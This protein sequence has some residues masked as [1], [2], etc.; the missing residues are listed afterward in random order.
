MPE[1]QVAH[2]NALWLAELA[3]APVTRVESAEPRAA[4]HRF[5]SRL[6]GD[7]I[8]A[9]RAVGKHHLL[10][11]AS[12]RVLHSHLRMS[13]SWRRFAP[14]R[15]PPRRGLWL[16]LHTDCGVAA[17]YRCPQVRLLEAHEPLPA[18]IAALGPDLLAEST[19]PVAATLDA[20]RGVDQD[21]PIGEVVLDQRVLAGIGNAY[22]AEALFVLGINPWRPVAE[23]DGTDRAELGAALAGMLADGVR[24]GGRIVT[25]R[26]PGARAGRWV[27]RR[28]GRPC[29]RCATPVRSRPMGDDG[30]IVYWCPTCQPEG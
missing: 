27:H 22:R 29:R 28:S 2:H 10:E 1:G 13:G 11:F 8:R 30:R 21:L 26:A 25:Y 24:D 17:L 12:G 20:L 14:D 23:V 3:G 15:R 18:P 7:T 6:A 5:S 9:A 16:A 19:D 4:L